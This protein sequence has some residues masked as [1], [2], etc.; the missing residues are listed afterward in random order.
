MQGYYSIGVISNEI[1]VSDKTLYKIAKKLGLD[2]KKIGD[3]EKQ[4]LIDE[5]KSTISNKKKS[6]AFVEATKKV[7]VEK[8]DDISMISG[9]T[10]EQRLIKAK[11]DYDY[12][13]QSIDK[14]KKLIDLQGAG[15]TN[16]NGTTTSNPFAKDVREF[17]KVKI[18]LDKSIS[19]LEEKLKLSKSTSEDK[20]SVIGDE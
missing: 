20:R 16:V 17:I 2:T 12:V 1:D 15:K 14:Y 19:E 9:S 10:L 18:A 13:S 3:K 7:K 11:K 6:K 4:M 8:S 5:C